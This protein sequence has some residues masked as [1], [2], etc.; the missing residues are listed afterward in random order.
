MKNK[1]NIILI[2]TIFRKFIKRFA[3]VLIFINNFAYY[4]SEKYQ[5]HNKKLTQEKLNNTLNINLYIALHKLQQLKHL[6]ESYNVPI[7]K[8]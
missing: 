5:P 8:P 3:I 6:D 7:R 2:I 1:V 4:T